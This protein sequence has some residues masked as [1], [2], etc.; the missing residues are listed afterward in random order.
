MQKQTMTRALAVSTALLALSPIGA[1]ACG[2]HAAEPAPVETAERTRVRVVATV[3]PHGEFFFPASARTRKRFPTRGQGSIHLDL[4]M[5]VRRGSNELRLFADQ[6][7]RDADGNRMELGFG[8]L[9]LRRRFRAAGFLQPYAAVGAVLATTE[10]RVPSERLDVDPDLIGGSV[11]L[12]AD[13]GCHGFVEARY[14][15]VPRVY[16]YDLS[17]LNL[18]GG[19]RF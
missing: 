12:G 9:E 7:E 13:L 16:G 10:L 19:V 17:G 3:R 2:C 4:S 6:I 15:T 8:G 14:L 1:R 5:R 11:L 18:R